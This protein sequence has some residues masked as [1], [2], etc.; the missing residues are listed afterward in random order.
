MSID[1]PQNEAEW[2]PL[3]SQGRLVAAAVLLGVLWAAESLAPMFRGRA[4]RL[5]HAGANLGLALINAGIGF[6]MAF[7]ILG[8]TAW[9]D[10][11]AFGIV[12]WVAMPVWAQWVVALL[13]FDCWQYWWHRL[14]HR[15]PLLWRFHAIHHADAEMDASSGVRF[16]T[17]EILLSFMARM[18]IL[19]LIGMSITQV[20][21]YEAITL[22]V[23]LFHHSNVKLGATADRSLRWLIVTP[24]MHWVHHSDYR[25]ETDSNYSSFLSVWD[26]LFRTFRLREKP[27]EIT[28]GLRGWERREWA[29]IWG[30]LKSPFVKRYPRDDNELPDSPPDVATGDTTKHEEADATSVPP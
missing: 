16:H 19:P 18:A 12:R 6:G 7:A 25:P 29:G 8:V 3:L 10:E 2:R 14:N 30:M 9:A 22:P 20:L 21:L 4:H 27:G 24:W 15:V 23:I 11:N 26:R 13:L 28:L 1:W 5:R 17:G